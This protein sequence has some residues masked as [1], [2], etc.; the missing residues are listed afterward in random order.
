MK[1]DI[2]MHSTV[3][4]LIIVRENKIQA[5]TNTANTVKMSSPSEELNP[6]IK[7]EAYK[8]GLKSHPPMKMEGIFNSLNANLTKHK[9]RITR[10]SCYP[11]MLF[12]CN[13]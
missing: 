12:F 9:E 1:I 5:E 8:F 2:R 3:S 7:G 6:K 10:N 13:P 11:I 4:F